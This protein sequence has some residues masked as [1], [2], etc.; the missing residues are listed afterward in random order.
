MAEDTPTAGD[1]GAPSS[2]GV[3]Q[4]TADTAAWVENPIITLANGIVLRCKPVPAAV[5][6]RIAI[7]IPLPSPPMVPGAGGELEENPSDPDYEKALAEAHD[8]RLQKVNEALFVLG[9]ECVSVPDGMFRPEEDGWV[10]PLLFVGADVDTSSPLARYKDWLDLYA[11]QLQS[12]QGQ[13]WFGV[14]GRSGILE[15]EVANALDSFRRR[16]GRRPDPVSSAPDPDDAGDGADLQP[17]P[18]RDSP[19]TRRAQRRTRAGL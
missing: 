9:T 3:P 7:K 18:P 17:E 10:E 16:S 8:E 5:Q 14:V 2:T 4:L 6:R 11:V 15:R 19:R 12:D 13:I 1:A